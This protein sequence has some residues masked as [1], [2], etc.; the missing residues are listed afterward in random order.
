MMKNLLI[1][2]IN[3]IERNFTIPTGGVH[4]PEPPPRHSRSSSLGTI[5]NPL[6]TAANAVAVNQATPTVNTVLPNTP[7][8]SAV[9][10]PKILQQ[11]PVVP[12]RITSPPPAYHQPQVQQHHQEVK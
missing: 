4:I 6:A 10:T 9:N 1:W 8:V 12:P 5:N 7:F 11:Q 2:L 3:Q